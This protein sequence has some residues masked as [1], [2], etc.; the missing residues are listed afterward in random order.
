[1]SDVVIPCDMARRVRR[2]PFLS[3]A[4][5]HELA[6]IV[7]PPVRSINLTAP[8]YPSLSAISCHAL[9]QGRLGRHDG[10]R[11]A[12]KRPTAGVPAASQTDDGCEVRHVQTV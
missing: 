6:V 3:T 4:H 12:R 8:S 10:R 2:H 9:P 7:W 1:M 5:L 11:T